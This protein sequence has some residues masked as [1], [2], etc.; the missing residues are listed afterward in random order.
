MKRY[1][2]VKILMVICLLFAGCFSCGPLKDKLYAPGAPDARLFQ[3]A[4]EKYRNKEYPEALSLYEKH[5]R[6][7]PNS[8]LAP[9]VFLRMGQIQ[10]ESQQYAKAQVLFQRVIREYPSSYS[11]KDAKIEILRVYYFIGKYQDVINSAGSIFTTELSTE[12]SVKFHRVVGDSHLALKSPV[13]AYHEFITA[14][15]NATPQ[16]MDQL[17]SRFK[18]VIPLL[19]AADIRFELKQAG[20][21]PPAG[22][23]MFYLGQK[24]MAE[25]KKDEALSTF[26]IFIEKFPDHEFAGQARQT[27]ADIQAP[28]PVAQKAIGC[29]LPLSGKYEAFGQQALKGVELALTVFARDQGAAS[30]NIHIKDNESQSAIA[31]QRIKELQESNVLAIIGPVAASE[32]AAAKAQELKIPIVTL[33][34]KSNITD[35]GDYVFRNFLTPEMQVKTLIQYTMGSLNISRFA[36]L[37]PDESYGNAF[38]KLFREEALKAGG[39]VSSIEAYRSDEKDFEDPVKR[40]IGYNRWATQEAFAKPDNSTGADA[41][42]QQSDLDQ[43]VRKDGKKELVPNV[44][45]DAVFIPDSPEKTGLIIPL[46]AYYGVRNIYL[47]GTNLWH[48]EKM[49]QITSSQIQ[50]AIIPDGFFDDAVLAENISG[51][52]ADFETTY[53][54]RPGFIEAVSYDTAMILLHLA[55]APDVKTPEDVKEKLLAMPPYP[56]VTGMTYFSQTGEAVKDIYLLKIISGKFAEIYYK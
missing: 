41:L 37:Y 17:I 45:F 27:M 1:K 35:V 15:K 22:Y 39:T 30:I 5:A 19:S 21:R 32:A 50:G 34:Q 54:Y 3:A 24:Y 28:A 46:F 13:K 49:I 8:D 29:L 51:F 38:M 18:T 4:E 23:L 56:G 40:L 36:I 26:A 33:T 2:E 44:D 31:E 53:G 11:A 10:I 42:T 7:F 20:D 6:E 14:W 48:S 55:A 25:G 43:E 52:V 12:Q 47:L 16:E 9:Q